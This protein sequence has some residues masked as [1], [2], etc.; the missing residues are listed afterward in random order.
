M[1]LVNYL[2]IDLK[3]ALKIRSSTKQDGL[4]PVSE[5]DNIIESSS[6]LQFEPLW[7]SSQAYLRESASQATHECVSN[8]TRVVNII[9]RFFAYNIEW[10][11]LL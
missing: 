3:I 2:N 8:Q 10:K 1:L 6:S 7:I 4:E 9:S 5:L 11:K